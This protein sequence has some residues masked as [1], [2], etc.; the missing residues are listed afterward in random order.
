M[1]FE[2]SRL[3]LGEDADLRYLASKRQGDV[4]KDLA[5]LTLHVRPGRALRLPYRD[6]PYE[7]PP[8]PLAVMILPRMFASS[9][10]SYRLAYGI[11]AALLTLLTCGLGVVVCRALGPRAPERPW[12]WMALFV[13]AIGPILVSRFDPLP[14][15]LVAGALVL[16]TR[17]R[18]FIAGLCGGAAVMAKLYPLLLVVPWAAMLWG[19][20]R[21]R[22]ALLLV[23]G[24]I[25]AIAAIAAPFLATAPAAFVRST[26]VYG[27]RPFQVEG[28]VGAL[29]VLAR[30][31]PAIVG[32]FGSYNV[33]APG[34]L[35]TVW[36]ALLPLTL[37]SCTILAARQARRT[38]PTSTADRV[39]R[40]LT[41]TC[42][43][44]T[45]ILVTSKVLSPQYLI[46]LLPVGVTTTGNV[47][48]RL[49]IA[50]AA[51]TQAFYPILYDLFVEDGSRLVALLV[52]LRNL[53]LIAL[54]IACVRAALQG[55]RRVE[56]AL[57]S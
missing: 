54:A 25:V 21:A 52:T 42:A 1:Y 7:Y 12:R 46:W 49:A 48:H 26:F 55:S 45:L 19:E 38:P 5:D 28:L 4:A 33:V 57:P 29:T 53:V 56:A 2:D 20:R 32:A 23:L 30:G 43:C 44:I 34:W 50:A 11:L 16:L 51:L 9:L 47:I 6:F 14:A 8:L 22:E 31:K 40:L 17:E 39:E 36:S 24:T 13:L 37:G 18:F 41:W 15:V 27:A 10:A 35:G 3:A